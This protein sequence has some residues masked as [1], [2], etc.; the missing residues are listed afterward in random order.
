MATYTKAELAKTIDHAVLKPDMTDD[1]VRAN[2]AMCRERGVGCLCVRP[3]DVALAA[4]ELAGSETIP[5]GVIGFPYGYNRTEAKALE[6]RLAIEDGAAELD[7][8]MNVGKLLSG[9]DAYVQADIEAVVAV[10]KPKGVPV[11]VILETTLLTP[12]QIAAACKLAEAAKADFV[13]TSTGFAGGGATPEAIDIMIKT[14]GDTMQVK[15]SGGIRTWEDAVGYLDQGCNRLGIGATEA[16]LDGGE[17]D[18][19]Y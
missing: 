16:V 17:A 12:E 1:D 10:A 14:V 11:K 15:A 6:A 8:V 3:S 18:G 7:M 5:A 9:E 13:K 19:D 4:H 2:A